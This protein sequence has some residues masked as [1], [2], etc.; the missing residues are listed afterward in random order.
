MSQDTAAKLRK[1]DVPA[2][3]S[4]CIRLLLNVAAAITIGAAAD[5]IKAGI[6][7]DLPPLTDAIW[8]LELCL[9]VILSKAA[10]GRACVA[11]AVA[12]GARAGAATA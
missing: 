10:V 9:H 5:A 8:P 2:C 3:S 12:M 4:T 1:T 6:L 11:L 7:Q